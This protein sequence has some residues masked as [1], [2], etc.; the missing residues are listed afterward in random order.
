MQF[1]PC[2][3]FEIT[4]LHCPVCGTTR[5][6]LA[7]VEGDVMTALHNNVLFVAALPFVV[8]ALLVW[9][10]ARFGGTR[11]PVARLGRRSSWAVLTVAL[12][13]AVLR[14]TGVDALAPIS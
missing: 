10:T 6:L 14:N 12:V 11:L 3:F 5:A 9:V 4:G 2:P 8:Y 1:L 7:L 13:F